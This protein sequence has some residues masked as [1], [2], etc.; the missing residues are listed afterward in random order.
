MGLPRWPKRPLALD[1]AEPPPGFAMEESFGSHGAIWRVI[2]PPAAGIPIFRTQGWWPPENLPDGRVWRWMDDE[3]HITVVARAAG[4]HRIGFHVAAVGAGVANPLK[5]R[6]PTG[7]CSVWPRDPRRGSSRWRCRSER[8]ATTSWWQTSARAP[9]PDLRGRSTNRLGQDVRMG[10]CAASGESVVG[11]F[12]YTFDVTVG[13]STRR[14]IARAL[15]APVPQPGPARGP[16]A[17]QGLGP[18]PRVDADHAGDDGRR[19][20]A[21]L[22]ASCCASRSRTTRCSCSWA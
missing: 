14:S 8:G 4:L 15:W 21:G 7:L 20:L 3:G 5:S 16:P 17:L 18:G 13:S 2:A 22:Q 11:A 1:P 19:V 10:T 6:A 12:P 9:S